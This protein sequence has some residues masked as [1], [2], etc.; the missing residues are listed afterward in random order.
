MLI[1][2]K[3]DNEYLYRRWL[4][5][6]RRNSGHLKRGEQVRRARMYAKM[7]REVPVV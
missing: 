4:A 7:G 1:E 2:L 6:L 3:I 5:Y